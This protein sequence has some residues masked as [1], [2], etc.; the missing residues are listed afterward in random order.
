VFDALADSLLADVLRVRPLLAFVIMSN[1]DN[2]TPPATLLFLRLAIATTSCS[3]CASGIG[4]TSEHSAADATGRLRTRPS[5]GNA[6]NRIDSAL[7]S[8]HA[9]HLLS[10]LQ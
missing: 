3:Y 1:M 9:F 8:S 10:M 2:C 5:A 7:N 4:C 6:S